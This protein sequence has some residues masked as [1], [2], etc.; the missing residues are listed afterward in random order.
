[1]NALQK[2]FVAFHV[3]L[4]RRS[5]GRWGGTMDR[6]GKVLLLTTKG[7]KTGQART[8]P[9]MYFDDGG[10]IFVSNSAAGTPT[11]PAWYLNLQAD[12]DVEVELAAER[13]PM[14]AIPASPERSLELWN[15]IC[16]GWPRFRS[17][18]PKAKGR[19]FTMVHLHPR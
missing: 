10:T 16:A 2:R 1:M 19:A 8:V 3:W 6:G 5:Q 17:Y 18:E 9:L 15:Q 11:P 14:R 13:V 4:F 7:R 12:P